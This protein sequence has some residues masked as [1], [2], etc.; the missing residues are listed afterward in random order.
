MEYDF[1]ETPK[2]FD[3]LLESDLGIKKITVDGILG[4]SLNQKI[5]L[6]KVAFIIFCMEPILTLNHRQYQSVIQFFI[7]S[8]FKKSR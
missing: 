1:K 8:C 7:L 2:F 3:K 4:L 6:S 5:E